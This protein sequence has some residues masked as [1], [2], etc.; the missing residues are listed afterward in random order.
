MANFPLLRANL[1]AWAV[2]SDLAQSEIWALDEG[3]QKTINATDG[4]THAPS[5]QIVLG[6]SGLSVTGPAN[7][8]NVTNLV[9]TAADLTGVAN[10]VMSGTNQVEYAPRTIQREQSICDGFGS[11]WAMSQSGVG[12]TRPVWAA[13]SNTVSYLWIRLSLPKGQILAGWRAWLRPSPGHAGV[14][15]NVPEVALYRSALGSDTATIV[16]AA[17]TAF[18]G[19]LAEYHAGYEPNANTGLHVVDA[20]YDYWIR[21]VNEF[22]ADAQLGLKVV[23]VRATLTV[24]SQDEA[25]V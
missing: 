16:A 7:L 11:N 8:A 18:S 3:R 15:A 4:S 10:L 25:L 19:T 17:A 2:G 9:A 22:G 23:S 21:V 13:E 24:T 1:A 6:G 5:T 12:A 20:G 14:P